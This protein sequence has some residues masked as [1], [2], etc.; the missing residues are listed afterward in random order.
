MDDYESAKAAIR[1]D[2]CFDMSSCGELNTYALFTE[3]CLNSLG[4]TGR[5]GII[6]KTSLV[7]MPVYSS[8]FRQLTESGALYE[9]YLFV[10][11]KKIFCIDSREEFSVAFLKSK[12]K[13]QLRLALNL[14]NFEDFGNKEKIC[15]SYQLLNK[16]NPETGMIPNVSSDEELEFLMS[17]YKS[18][19]V[20]GLIYPE[21][22]FGRLVH[23]TNHSGSILKR[24]E[25]GYLPIYEG[26]FI[27]I[28]TGKFAT[29]KGM[30]D[31][32]KYKNK[33]TARLI[34]D[35][36]GCEY[37]QSRFYIQ[38]EVWEN[39]SRNFAGDYVIAWRS[40]TSATN[41][42]TMLATFLP[43]MPT[44]QSIQLLQLPKEKMLHILA[45]FNSIVFDY[46]VRL[47]MAGLDLTQT[48]IKQIPVPDEV[49]YSKIITFKKIEATIEEHINSRIR[50][51]YKSDGR[52]I[53][54]F[55]NVEAYELQPGKTRKEIIAEID[56]LV[57]ILYSVDEEQLR[58]I[59]ST[60]TKYYSRKEVE[61]LF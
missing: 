42:R 50:E 55:S 59:A 9:L 11:R 57:A 19:K 36:D 3:L 12:N 44:C 28:Y 10:N 24:E 45:L 61:R 4:E 33:A 56:S 38:N 60:F 37:P 2:P 34:E 15:I 54:L 29:F 49:S 14:D 27:E 5:A 26:K 8:F 58:K 23:L 25:K 20:F 30:S 47:K 51:L 41:R 22:R 48:I 46:I 21:C 32:E 1:K 43:L 17:I 7:K 40:L 13:G 16:L 18:H 39:L 35:V 52:I 53:G 6:V 31:S